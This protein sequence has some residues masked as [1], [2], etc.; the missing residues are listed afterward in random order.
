[1]LAKSGPIPR[2][3]DWAFEV[4]LDGFRALV[5]TVAASATDARYG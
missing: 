5:A 2:R 3:G 4:K 1:M